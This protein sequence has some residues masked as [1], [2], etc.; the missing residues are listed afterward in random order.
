M[1]LRKKAMDRGWSA[2]QSNC[3]WECSA[4]YKIF[5]FKKI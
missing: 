3:L 4:K 2:P 5:N 1:K